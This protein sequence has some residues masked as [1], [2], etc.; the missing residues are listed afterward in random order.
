[1]GVFTHT[2]IIT[3]EMLSIVG[4][5]KQPGAINRL[6]HPVIVQF[7][8]DSLIDIRTS[9]AKKHLISYTDCM[10]CRYNSYILIGRSADQLLHWNSRSLAKA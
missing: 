10:L 5:R 7:K 3:S 6:H 9:S 1:M 8:I 4:E 2:L